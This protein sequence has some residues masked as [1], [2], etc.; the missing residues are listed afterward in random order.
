M[1]RHWLGAT[2]HAGNNRSDAAGGGHAHAGA[3]IYL[4]DAWPEEYRN[5]LFMNNIHGARLNVDQLTAQRV[6]LRGR[7][8]ARLPLRQ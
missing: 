1:H 8:V 4:G 2:P 5:R 3:M 6:W 7:S